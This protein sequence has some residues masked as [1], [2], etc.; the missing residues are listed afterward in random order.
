MYKLSFLFLSVF[1]SLISCGQESV[2]PLF[3]CSKK[4]NSP[5]GV[6]AQFTLPWDSPSQEEQIR[7]IKDADIDNVRYDFWVPYSE[8]LYGNKLLPVIE[9]ATAKS[10]DAELNI[11][12]VLFVGY[13]GQRSWEMPD[14]Y[15]KE[16]DYFISK[17]AKK[18]KY[19]EI[20]NEVNLTAKH[21][22]IPLDSTAVRYMSL[23]PKS[24]KKL[25]KANPNIVVTT[26][27]LGDV[28]DE[29]LELLCRHKAYKYFDVLS[30]H[31]YES[32][33]GFPNKFKKIKRIMNKYHWNK[34]VWISECGLTTYVNSE[35]QS[36]TSS[37]A[38]RETEQAYR[39]ARM[40]II[41]FSYG[42]DKVYTYKF[43][44]KEKDN[45]DPEDYYGIIHADLTPKPAY[46]AYKAMTKMLPSGSSRPT[47]EQDGNNYISSWTRNDGK[48]MW[49]LW[50]SK[51]TST[52]HLN[53]KGKADIYDYLGEHVKQPISGEFKISKGVTY[54]M[55]EKN[56]KVKE[57]K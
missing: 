20:L 28:D 23:L 25:K 46:L 39:I 54:I 13:R 35:S 40:H 15:W 7:L 48:K 43:R 19:W 45:K 30:F 52:M 53:I 50:N 22:A 42:V 14:E 2:T 34:P 32:P 56:L 55:G 10:F 51:G 57:I 3:K 36:Y 4:L 44:A 47:L 11:L 24:Y 16:I 37:M 31:S 18:L 17:Y 41:A 12:A 26:S 1:A 21:D 29:F 49:A 6:T 33:E 8:P 27:G 38:L 5:Y 9:N